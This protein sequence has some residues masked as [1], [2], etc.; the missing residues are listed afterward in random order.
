M[1]NGSV[2]DDEFNM[3]ELETRSS[4]SR[5][6]K[7]PFYIASLD[8]NSKDFTIKIRSAQ[9]FNPLQRSSWCAHQFTAIRCL[10]YKSQ[11]RTKLPSLHVLSVESFMYMTVGNR[12]QAGIFNLQTCQISANYLNN[13]YRCADITTHL[14]GLDSDFLRLYG[15]FCLV[16]W[17]PSCWQHR[18]MERKQK[19]HEQRWN[20]NGSFRPTKTRSTSHV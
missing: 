13:G 12:F 11:I 7:M 17:S 14:R 18:S 15:S 8:K 20:S 19:N 1:H 3:L 6:V 10:T 16:E 9:Q 5:A 4:R 2:L